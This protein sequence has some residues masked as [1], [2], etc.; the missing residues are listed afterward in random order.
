MLTYYQPFLLPFLRLKPYALAAGIQRRYFLS[1][2]DALWT[3]LTRK[4]VPKGS[5][6]LIPSFWCMDV[7]D[8]IR[9]H[10]Y[11]PVFY[12]LDDHFE[13]PVKRLQS[14]I[15]KHRPRVIILF[16]ACG[17]PSTVFRNEAFVR[18]IAAGAIVIE[19]CVQQLVNP[20]EV[21]IRHP[22]HFVIDSLRKVSPLSGSFIY[23]DASSP[24]IAPRRLPGELWYVMGT[25]GLYLLFRGV[26]MLAVIAGR[27][28]LVS[29]THLR[30]LKAHD[31]LVG[32]S[33]FGYRGWFI[34]GFL[35]RFLAVDRIRQRKQEQCALYRKLLAPLCRH[36]SPWYQIHIK[37]TDGK[38]L[39]VY[40]LGLHHNGNTRILR[41]I[42]KNLLQNG[43]PV[44]F[45]FTDAPW[46]RHRAVLF[47]PLGF[48]V[49]NHDIHKIC[50]L[51]AK[52]SGHTAGR[53]PK[54]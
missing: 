40:P 48:H 8:N 35:H 21:I 29:Y 53:Q 44:W 16:H 34:D 23:G 3:L 9:N 38:L 4:R 37:E 6:V 54:D 22:N 46:C 17:I 11:S 42:E 14:I 2:E 50:N 41:D 1:F 43:A 51:L 10:G 15:R 49:S 24:T 13:I 32:D 33:K 30:I 39:H 52:I 20:T 25:V 19:D 45:K 7:V 12:P 27:A 28:R 47:L 18:S 5:A 26:F 36:R 31:N